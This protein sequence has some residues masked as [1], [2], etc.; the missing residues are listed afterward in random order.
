L[1]L[2]ALLNGIIEGNPGQGL[3]N[4]PG[5]NSPRIPETTGFVVML[6]QLHWIRLWS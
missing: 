3:A 2:F 6:S 4:A 1:Y 5:A